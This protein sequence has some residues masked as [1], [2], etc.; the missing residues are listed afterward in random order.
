MTDFELYE[1]TRI[2]WGVN[3][4]RANE[5]QYVF[6]VYNG[7]IK[8]IYQITAWLPAFSTM[9]TLIVDKKIKKRNGICRVIALDKIRINI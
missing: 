7:M 2:S 5:L 8:E 1:A 9:N 6:A 4:E 3:K